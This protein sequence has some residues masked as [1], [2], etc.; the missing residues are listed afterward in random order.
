MCVVHSMRTEQFNVEYRMP[1]VLSRTCRLF[2]VCIV[3]VSISSMQG[4]AQD[5]PTG[6]LNKAKES[7]PIPKTLADVP[8]DDPIMKAIRE[9]A[10]LA[11]AKGLNASNAS[12]ASSP[13]DRKSADRKSAD[14]K[15]ADRKSAG[16]SSSDR[17]RIAERLLR[18]ARIMERD[19]ES[20][21]QL[22]DTD[23]A[24]AIRQLVATTREQVVRIL[25]SAPRPLEENLEPN[26]LLKK[27]IP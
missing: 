25:Q 20:L 13:S 22:G 7:A 12:E 23:A 26:L 3:I 8:S 24:D 6:T 17:W 4:T 14:R 1:H 15:S 19:A 27:T 18:Q 16:P 21:E 10:A 2:V 9:R 5:P 11:P